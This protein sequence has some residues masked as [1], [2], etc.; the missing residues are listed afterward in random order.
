V[1]KVAA[2]VQHCLFNAL[3]FC[4][5]GKDLASLLKADRKVKKHLSPKEID[6]AIE[7]IH[8]ALS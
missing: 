3:F 5:T 4:P 1:V 8:E 2:P 7:V 6:A